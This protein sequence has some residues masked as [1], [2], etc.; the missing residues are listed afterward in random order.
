M[1]GGLSARTKHEIPQIF[2]TLITWSEAT[3]QKQVVC[4]PGSSKE[5]LTQHYNMCFDW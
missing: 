1:G 2:Y 3:L 5:E 4:V